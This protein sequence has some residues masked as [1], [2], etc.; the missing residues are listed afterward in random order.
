MNIFYSCKLFLC[1]GIFCFGFFNNN[2]KVNNINY[3]RNFYTYLSA[4]V[5]DDSEDNIHRQWSA[6]EDR[7]LYQL[8]VNN[9][10]KDLTEICRLLKRSEGSTESNQRP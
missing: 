4:E 5:E 1:F 6:E 2:Y 7:L 9:G 10:K 8:T 3:R